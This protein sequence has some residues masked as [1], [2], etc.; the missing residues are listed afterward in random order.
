MNLFQLEIKLL[1]LDSQLSH[2][3][4]RTSRVTGNEVG[5]N[6]LIEVFLTIDAIEDALEVIELLERWLTHEVENT[7][8]GMLRGN[9]QT[10]TDVILDEFTSVFHSSLIHC[11]ILTLMQ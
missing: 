7:L 11:F 3:R 4:F 5:D 10:T 1:G 8:A 2:I 9:L 6:L